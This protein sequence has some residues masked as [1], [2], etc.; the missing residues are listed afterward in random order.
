MPPDSQTTFSF[1]RAFVTSSEAPL[2]LRAPPDPHRAGPGSTYC[3]ASCRRIREPY[4]GVPEF[5]ESAGFPADSG[6]RKKTGELER[7]AALSNFQSRPAACTVGTGRFLRPE[8]LIFQSKNR[9]LTVFVPGN[10][11]D[12]SKNWRGWQWRGSL[13]PRHQLV[14]TFFDKLSQRLETLAGINVLLALVQTTRLT[15][16]Y[17]C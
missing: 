9:F 17:D 10:L 14:K 12:F 13:L 16:G 1:V 11:L 4:I 2:S 3:R 5:C 8:N 15:G 6:C 7:V